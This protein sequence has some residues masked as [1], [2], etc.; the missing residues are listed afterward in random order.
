MAK[1]SK[2]E[3]LSRYRNRL[4]HARRWREEE[5][6]DDKWERMSDLYLGKHFPEGFDD[7]D[8]IAINMAFSTVNVIFPSITV[9]HPKIEVMA[10]KPEDEDRAVIAQAVINYLWRHYNFRAPFRR[11]AKDFVTFGHGWVKVGYKFEE[12]E[13][14]LDDDEKEMKSLELITEVDNFVSENP[15]LAGDMPDDDEIRANSPQTKTIVK[16]DRPTV[17]RI[18]VF[19]MF[20]DPEATCME[21]A[22]WIAQRIVLP[23]DEVKN[24]ERYNSSVRRNLKADAMI[25]SEWMSDRDRKAFD[26]DIDRVTIYEFYDIA[27]GTM[28]V[29]AEGGDGYLIDPVEMPYAFGHPFEYIPNYEVPDSFYAIGDLEMIEAPQQELNKTRS[30]MMNHRK[31]YGRKYL[32]RASA[33]GPEGRQGLES[34]EDN[35]AIEVVDDNQ[36]LQD[37]IMPVPITP[38]SGDLYQYS[39][40]IS[41]DMDRVSGVNEYAR[42]S[43][44][45]IRRTATE[46]AMIQDGANARSADKL[47]IIELAIGNIAR[48][49]LQLCQQYMT[50]EQVARV[51]GM[52][53]QQF[54]FQYSHEDIEGE[55]DFSVEGGSTQPQNETF[56]RQQAVAMMNALGPFIGQIIDPVEMV[57]HVLQF[58]FGVKAPAKFLMQQQPPMLPPGAEQGGVPPEMAAQMQGGAPMPMGATPPPGQGMDAPQMDPQQLLA[59]QQEAMMGGDMGV[60]AEEDTMGMDMGA[61]SQL[62]RGGIPPEL[63][64]QIQN[65]MNLQ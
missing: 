46:A 63:I 34:S 28:C 21:D 65:Q 1:L 43:T 44:P 12:E 35:V 60:P 3:K 5:G 19:D 17:E 26:S 39:N 61:L 11:A 59:L 40:I 14:E 31:K 36:P 32:Y 33:L 6:Y 2:S 24:D 57:R 58:G 8:R 52:D 20:V 27:D 62:G 23:I 49:V 48:K 7:E 30:Q 41:A 54:W 42:G 51:V 9:N 64:R 55:F 13:V 10:N 29:F 47:A 37:V 38:M 15:D 53:G 18:S 50:G 45:E 22:R 25:T 56:R 16:E 4:N